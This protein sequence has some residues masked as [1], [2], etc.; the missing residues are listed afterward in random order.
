MAP[1]TLVDETTNKEGALPEYEDEPQ[2]QKP[3]VC[4]YAKEFYFL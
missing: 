3:Y 2:P 4:N 1:P